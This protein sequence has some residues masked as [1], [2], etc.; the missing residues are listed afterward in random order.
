[1]RRGTRCCSDGHSSSARCSER[2]RR[3]T[4]EMTEQ[5]NMVNPVRIGVVASGALLVEY[6][7]HIA[8]TP[9]AILAGL[10][11]SDGTPRELNRIPQ[12]GSSNELAEADSLDAVIVASPVWQRPADIMDGIGAGKP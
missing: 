6:A 9:G 2:Q 12:F 5:E 1:M 8:D 10:T 7:Q 11:D 4:W 3:K